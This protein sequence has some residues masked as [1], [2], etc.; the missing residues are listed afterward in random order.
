[1]GHSTLTPG[2][3]VEKTETHHGSAA[4]T[5]LDFSALPQKSRAPSQGHHKQCH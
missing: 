5:E 1:M 2:T 4:W 3:P